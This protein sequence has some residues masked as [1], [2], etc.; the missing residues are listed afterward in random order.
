MAT[1]KKTAKA[2]AKKAADMPAVSK[3]AAPA[4]AVS[5]AVKKNRSNMSKLI[6]LG[7]LDRWDVKGRQLASDLAAA[8][9]EIARGFDEIY[10]EKIGAIKKSDLLK[11]EMMERVFLA[12]LGRWDVKHYDLAVTLANVSAEVAD[13]FAEVYAARFGSSAKETEEQEMVKKAFIALLD[14]WDVNNRDLAV[15]LGKVAL[16]IAEGYCGK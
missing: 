8:S 13:G 15:A 5:A 4:K 2:P 10:E 3:A 6:F 11:T 12:L 1:V 9:R 7:L 14:R 16:E